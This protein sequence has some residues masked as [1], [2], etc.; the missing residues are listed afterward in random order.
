VIKINVEEYIRVCSSAKLVQV[1]NSKNNMFKT[2]DQLEGLE[3]VNGELISFCIKTNPDNTKEKVLNQPVNSKDILAVLGAFAEK[4]PEVVEEEK[5]KAKAHEHYTG[6]T[7]I[8]NQEG[9]GIVESSVAPC[10]PNSITDSLYN[11]WAKMSIPERLIMLQNTDSRQVEERKGRA[12]KKYK[13]VSISYM[14][15]AANMAFGFAWSI[16]V[17]SWIETA[18]EIICNVELSFDLDGKTIIKSAT[19]QKDLTFKKDSKDLLCKGDDYKAAEADG[20]KKALSFCGIA[21]DVYSG[22]VSEEV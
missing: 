15:K 22:E 11:K 17:V 21:Q 14:I 2:P 6:D 3:L 8:L 19:G 10:M 5:A 18:T 7:K 4:I 12:G 20:I 16:R 13:Y 9:S 1:S